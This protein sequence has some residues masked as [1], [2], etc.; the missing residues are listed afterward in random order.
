MLRVEG[1]VVV[2]RD[3]RWE[4]LVLQLLL[5]GLGPLHVVVALELIWLLIPTILRIV[6]W[7]L[8]LLL[9]L[10]ELGHLRVVVALVLVWLLIPTVPE[11]VLW[12]LRGVALPHYLSPL[13]TLGI[14]PLERERALL[15]CDVTLV[16]PLGISPGDAEPVVGDGDALHLAHGHHGVATLR[17]L[18]ERG[19]LVGPLHVGDL[20]EFPELFVDHTISHYPVDAAD[21]QCRV[22]QISEVRAVLVLWPRRRVACWV[23]LTRVEAVC[24]VTVATVLQ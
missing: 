19:G 3:V 10:A 23:D 1:H 21:E 16:H 9:S 13:V 24:A 14:H 20:P 18:D 8:V 12:R 11:I 7:Y 15:G 22:L 17:V 4:Q 2:G 5:A 6:L